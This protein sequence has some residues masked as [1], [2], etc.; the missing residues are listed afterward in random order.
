MTGAMAAS[1]RRAR[2][3]FSP[4][5]RQNGSRSEREGRLRSAHIGRGFGCGWS[6]TSGVTSVRSGVVR[7]VARLDAHQRHGAEVCDA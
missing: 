1:S 4:D 5:I 3:G 6:R 7:R 2:K